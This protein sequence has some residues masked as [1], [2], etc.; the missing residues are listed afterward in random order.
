MAVLLAAVMLVAQVV[1]DGVA[2]ENGGPVEAS[3]GVEAPEKALSP[4]VYLYA[5]YPRLAR[6]L[7]CM[8]FR[9]SSWNASASAVRG[10][11]IGLA[12]FDLPTWYETPQGRAGASRYDPYA[13]IDAMAWGVEHL[14]YG[15]WPVTSRRC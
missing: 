5:S 2:V 4:R 3:I 9:E 15:R 10:R 13:S 7:D 6:R 12:Q 1:D 14:G 8:I 11:Y